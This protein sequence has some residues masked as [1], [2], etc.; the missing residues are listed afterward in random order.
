VDRENKTLE[1]ITDPARRAKLE[2]IQEVSFD[3]DEQLVAARRQ[4]AL[5]RNEAHAIS[6]IAEALLGECM[7]I[8]N[9]LKNGI[10]S[11]EETTVRVDQTKKI[12][13]Q[14]DKLKDE[15]SSST[16]TLSHKIEGLEAAIKSVAERFE[17]EARKA[18]RYQRQEE[19]DAAEAALRAGPKPKPKSKSRGAKRSR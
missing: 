9:D 3:L 8:T 18:E 12:I 1:E 19:E 17:N 13:E 2:G 16:R 6:K 4:L 14:L 5:N 7:R 10:Y 15:S 11:K